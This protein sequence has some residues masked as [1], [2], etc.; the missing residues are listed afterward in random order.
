MAYQ[1][2]NISQNP[3][4]LETICLN[5]IIIHF[6]RMNGKYVKNK[7]N[8]LITANGHKRKR[9]DKS[10]NNFSKVVTSWKEEMQSKLLSDVKKLDLPVFLSD[11]LA[12][13][14]SVILDN[15]FNWI[16]LKWYNFPLV[17]DI[18]LSIFHFEHL[19]WRSNGIVH[20]KK[21]YVSHLCYILENQGEVLKCIKKRYSSTF[22]SVLKLIIVHFEM[23]IHEK[24]S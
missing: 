13:K 11:S 9:G 1:K 8:E 24:P 7:V 2:K 12:S 10:N 17:S 5:S 14:C 22:A 15:M 18:N 19:F 6:I 16:Y 23:R 3:C 4:S 21:T 20:D